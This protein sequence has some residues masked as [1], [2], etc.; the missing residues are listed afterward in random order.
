MSTIIEIAGK[1][2]LGTEEV[3][4][5]D[6]G[7][8]QLTAKKA[9]ALTEEFACVLRPENCL[10][11]FPAWRWN[12]VVNQLL[13]GAAFDPKREQMLR[14]FF[15]RA[16]E[17]L[18]IDS[19]GRMLLPA[20]SRLQLKLLAGEKLTV[21]GLGG[22]MDVWRTSDWEEFQKYPDAYRKAERDQ[23]QTL[24]DELAARDAAAAAREAQ[25]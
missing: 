11:I 12:Q 21:V 6:R 5:D 18:S 17:G 23:F 10:T 7:R 1:R 20:R 8:V 2:L 16:E 3:S 25:A 24:W 19:Q 15:G 22:S 9:A 14:Q 4:L 13:G